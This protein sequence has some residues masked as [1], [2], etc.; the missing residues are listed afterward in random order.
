[1][2]GDEV[3]QTK[4]GGTGFVPRSQAYEKDAQSRFNI[5]F[6]HNDP[7]TFYFEYFRSGD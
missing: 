5:S 1:L 4:F 6:L 3:Q 2:I 7:R